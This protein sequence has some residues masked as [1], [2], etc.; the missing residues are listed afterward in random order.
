MAEARFIK[1]G[2]R[3]HVKDKGYVG[4][5]A[6]VGTTLFASGKWI[7]VVLDD[8]VGKNDGVV[9]GKRYFDC[10]ENRGIFVRQSQVVVLDDSVCEGVESPGVLTPLTSPAMR[11]KVLGQ[12]AGKS[13]LKPPSAGA[14]RKESGGKSAAS[15][16]ETVPAAT[17]PKV[18]AQ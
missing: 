8:P 7:G 16:P 1:V 12:T 18:D 11:R 9:Q 2:H 15:A 5:V 14:M 6:Y 17:E 4:V 10:E 13:G 3:V